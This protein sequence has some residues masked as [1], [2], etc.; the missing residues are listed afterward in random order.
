MNTVRLAIDLDGVLTE[1]P[2]R[3]AHAAN[4]AFDL[5]LPD[6]AFVDSAGLNVP[7]EVR[8]WVYFA[9]G[10]A[11][12]LEPAPWAQEFLRQLIEAFGVDRIEIITARPSCVR[13]P[14]LE[15]LVRNE[16]P[17]VSVTFAEDKISVARNAGVTHAVEDSVRHG[18]EYARHGIRCCLIS[19]QPGQPED[20]N[21]LIRV[22]D[23]RSAF[24]RL[25]SQRSVNPP[26]L[27]H[28]DLDNTK[29]SAGMTTDDPITNRTE[30]RYRIV[31][32]DVIDDRAR[33]LLS[34]QAELVDV[35]GTDAKELAVALANADALIV[36][37]ETEVSREILAAAPK[38]KLVARAGVGVDNIDVDAATESGVL[39]L[40]APGANAISA[41]EHTLALLLA[42]TRS[43]PDANTTTH[44]GLWERKRYK[45]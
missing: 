13:E 44:A 16:F 11:S 31:V 33:Q 29:R 27:D 36:R 21:R 40:N 23:L 8:E 42:L 26:S 39:V 38:L 4:E 37:S 9:G 24:D 18:S 41:A 10:P 5:D 34:R 12:S 3:L 45:P 28:H 32:S 20:S 14:T 25:V 35:N 2:V 6:H 1:P 43:I 15:W 19:P 7:R 30:Q 22:P 17:H